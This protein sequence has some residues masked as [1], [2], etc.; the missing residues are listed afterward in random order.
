M[1]TLSNLTAI[2]ADTTTTVPKFSHGAI[3]RATEQIWSNGKSIFIIANGIDHAI[4]LQGE[5]VQVAAGDGVKWNEIGIDGGEICIANAA[6]PPAGRIARGLQGHRMP[7]AEWS[8]LSRRIILQGSP[9][10]REFERV[11]TQAALP[12]SG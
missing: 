3:N 4:G 6:F 12:S 5:R 7:P 2:C 1:K 11:L 10:C 8:D 9:K